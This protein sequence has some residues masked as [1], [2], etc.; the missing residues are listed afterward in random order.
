M[1]FDWR[2]DTHKLCHLAVF[3][4]KSVRHWAC[5]SFGLFVIY[6]YCYYFFFEL[7][8][9]FI[10]SLDK[11]HTSAFNVL[12]KYGFSLTA[13]CRF[14]GRYFLHHCMSL[15]WNECALHL[16]LRCR[17]IPDEDILTAFAMIGWLIARCLT[18]FPILFKLYR[19]GQ[20]TAFPSS[21]RGNNGEQWEGNESCCDD[22]S[23]RSQVLHTTDWATRGSALRS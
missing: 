18:Q 1:V 15:Y 7:S 22:Q 4:L 8:I 17:N 21:N 11:Y 6:Y 2:N 23:S 5:S 19:S 20:C 14:Q 16:L 10:G 3:I 9:P 12:I 13:N